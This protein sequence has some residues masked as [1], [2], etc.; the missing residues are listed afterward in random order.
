MQ[1]FIPSAQQQVFFN[2]V[3]DD[4]GSCVL[5]A[6]AGAGKTTT[7]VHALSLMSGKVFFGAY[8][9]KIA[10]EIKAK[11]EKAGLT[12][13]NASTMHAEGFRIWGR[14]R[15][16][17][18]DQ[19]KCR[20]IFRAKIQGLRSERKDG[21]AEELGRFESQILSLVSYAKQAGVGILKE[22]SDDNVWLAMIDHFNIDCL[23]ND[24]FVVRAARGLLKKS[25]SLNET[26]IDFDDMIYAPLIGGAKAYGYDWVLIDEAQD[27]NATRRALAQ[28]ILKK[29]GRLVAVGDR[30][31]AIYGFTG[32]D[33]DALDLIAEETNA[34]RLPLTT[35]YR[36]PKS[37]VKFAQ[38]WVSH[39]QAAD[40]APEGVVRRLADNEKV[41]DAAQLGDAILCRFN[42]PLIQQVYEFIA[43]GIPAKVEGREI[44]NGLKALARRW[45]VK[46]YD[47]M[48]VNL[49]KYLDRETNKYRAKEEESKAV[50]VEDKVTCLM[51]IMNR[52]KANA[53]YVNM[54]PV[55]S[56]CAEIDRIFDDNIKGGYI[57]LSTIH[58]SKGREWK[59]VFW[60]E[61]GPSKWAV[62]QW[63]IE[64]EVNLCYV[65]ATRAM[66][67]LVLFPAPAKQ[68]KEAA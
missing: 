57:T 24:M 22:A 26:E 65:A 50:A 33:S 5:E 11:V 41:S 59:R 2:W 8:N 1:K 34:T 23:E 49:E 60:M 29:G 54:N 19:N 31:Q 20:N 58:K 4:I 17:K 28:M 44:G 45:K 37:V 46:S 61:T 15:K 32:A 21:E 30:H 6:V 7:L 9:K 68:Q 53:A 52:A 3:S 43:A 67:E 48:T 16:L 25:V 40:S 62:K 64:Q 18:V 47:A 56:V 63:E 51:V 14:G 35:T 42:A 55:D 10:E 13:V 27:T 12:H 66:E 38:Q 39:I 36:C